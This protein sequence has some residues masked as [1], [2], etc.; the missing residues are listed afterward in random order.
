[1]A[2]VVEGHVCNHLQFRD[3]VERVV[4][5]GFS[6]INGGVDYCTMSG[7][8]LVMGI[9]KQLFS[10]TI[11]N[12]PSYIENPIYVLHNIVYPFNQKH[13]KAIGKIRHIQRQTRLALIDK[14]TGCQ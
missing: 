13:P 5:S 10:F 6:E 1:M 14:L 12:S 2:N 11:Q 7:T 9:R 8:V 4:G 3:R